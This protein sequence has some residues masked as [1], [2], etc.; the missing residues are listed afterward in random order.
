MN[1]VIHPFNRSAQSQIRNSRLILVR[2]SNIWRG[3]GGSLKASWFTSRSY[4]HFP[5]CY[6][7][8]ELVTDFASKAKLKAHKFVQSN[9]TDQEQ[10]EDLESAT[11]RV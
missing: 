4:S 6:S 8:V 7:I 11:S 1:S 2:C 9:G 5:C 3:T 10:Q